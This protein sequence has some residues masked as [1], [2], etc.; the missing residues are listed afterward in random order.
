VAI[1]YYSVMSDSAIKTVTLAEWA[2]REAI[3]F[4]V[5]SPE[6]F[7]A[8]VDR[9]V[10]A[11]GDSEECRPGWPGYVEL[12]GLGEP[13]HGASEFLVLR[14]RLFQRLV[15]KHRFTAIALESSFPR[16]RIVND[17][18]NA[19]AG[20]PASYDDVQDS[21]FS[22]GFG[23]QQANR[24]LVEWMRGYNADPAHDVKLRFYGFD[25]PTEMMWSDSPRRLIEFVL[26]YLASKG[27]GGE[28]RRRRI[29]E[30]LG[31]DAEWENEAAA[32][33]P[34]KSIG[35]SPA[36]SALRIEV[37]EIASELCVRRPEL[38]AD[39]GEASY[40]E[41]VQ[42]VAIARQ[43]LNYHASVARPS[44]KRI[45]DLLGIRDAM[46]AS[47][48][49]YTV[50]REWSRGRILAFA[51][52]SHLLR[53]S[54]SWQFGAELLEWWPAGAHLGAMLGPR[55]AV[56]GMGVGT[57]EA[58]GI[59]PPEPGTL[60]AH[61]TTARGPGRFIPTHAGQVFNGV[62]IA[63]LATRSGGTKNPGYFPFTRNSFTDFDWLA[64]LDSIG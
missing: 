11:L 9:M 19:S 4:D 44:K 49:A 10:A 57:S 22:H 55:Y 24:E 48:L 63:S 30:L 36:A 21:G 18:V 6:S 14:N 56:I 7:H 5:E 42:Y 39:N 33:D 61:L 23:R 3:S 1:G 47:N 28:E 27:D 54:A 2:R 52:N 53:G 26:E 51:H 50:E 38:G 41:A 35:L 20:A 46:M 58:N 29:A 34:A 15:E 12:L 64:V 60:E 17:F 25:S 32:F 13:M 8:A 16:A 40:L 45:A 43:L 59:A 31:D 62:E 37:E